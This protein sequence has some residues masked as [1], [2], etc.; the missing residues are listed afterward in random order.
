MNDHSLFRAD[1]QDPDVVKRERVYGITVRQ[2]LEVD[3]L[4]AARVVAGHQGLDHV[5]SFVNIMEVPEVTR[6][7]KGGE[8]LVTSGF[9]FKNNS[10]E[11]RKLIFD[12]AAKGVAAFGIKPGQYLSSIP[13]DMMKW[14]D[15]VGLP[16]IE[17]P[18]DLPYMD[19]MVPIYEILIG[20]QVA[21]LKKSEQIHNQ[22]LEIVL[23][24]NGLPSVCHAL[25]ELMGNPVLILGDKSDFLASAWPSEACGLSPEIYEEKILD[26]LKKEKKQLITLNP[27]RLHRFVL[28]IENCAQNLVIVPIDVNGSLNGFLVIPETHRV[29]DDQDMMAVEHASTIVALEFL[30]Q[31][32]V[33]ETEKQIRLE[34]LEDIISGNFRTEEDVIRR[35]GHQNF[36]LDSPTIVFVIHFD[37]VP[38]SG[39][40]D[41]LERRL[42]DKFFQFVQRYA[43][44]YLGGAM[45]MARSDNVTGLVRV[46]VY[47]NTSSLRKAINE[48]KSK[49]EANWPNLKISI[50]VGRSVDAVRKIKKSYEE[51]MDAL[52]IAGFMSTESSVTFFEDLGVYSFLFELEGSSAMHNFFERTVGKII[53]YDRQNN[54]VLFD[55]LIQYFKCDCNLRV[56]AEQL[57]IHKNTVLYRIRKVEEITG[58]SMNEPEQRFNL[59]LGLKISRVL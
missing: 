59:Q 54:T 52:R 19:F 45:L 7:M 18:Q 44:D 11:C 23:N 34:L 5:I 9:A 30:K 47:N 26:R 36:N 56:T 38:R 48:L 6:W 15:E 41:G 37:A 4:R 35:A 43:N 29:L 33:Y 55:T 17:I 8:L 28:Q 14:A 32:I 25:V 51:A 13:E 57:Y 58:L 20:D 42:K 3:V 39:L 21:R 49:A 2:A 53:A 1:K 16:L 12:L 40:N 27:H 22:L 46:P 50:G 10:E 24:G 31:R